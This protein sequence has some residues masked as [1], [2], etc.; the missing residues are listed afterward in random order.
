MLRRG[1]LVVLALAALAGCTRDRAPAGASD[2]FVGVRAAGKTTG[3]ASLALYAGYD[4]YAATP[5]ANFARLKAA[6][7]ELAKVGSTDRLDLFL[8]GDSG[9]A[10]D[11]FR[12]RVAR[13]QAWMGP[14][15]E[16]LGELRTND[17]PGLRDYLAWTERGGRPAAAHVAILTHGGQGGVLLDQGG[18]PT[19]PVRS[20]TLQNAARAL[21]KG[22]TGRRLDSLTLDACMMGT[23]ETGEAL[24]GVAAVLTASEDLAMMGA[25]P[26]DEVVAPL[27]E[28]KATDGAAFGAHLAEAI[29]VRGRWGDLNSRTWSALRLDAGWDRL[30]R[31]VD[32]LAGA[33]LDA[34]QA[35][36]QAVRD[37]AR[38]MPPFA[39]MKKYE[40]HYGDFHQ[41]DLVGFCRLLRAVVKAPAV[42]AAA[43]AVEADVQGVLIAFHR[44][45]S[46]TMANGLAIHLPAGMAATKIGPYLED[47]R[48]SAFARHTRWDEFLLALNGAKAEP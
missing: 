29:V 14:G 48:G 28:G 25:T 4:D 16:A 47:Y 15:F 17:T 3:R 11:S 5:E 45:P 22:H 38:A 7:A 12:A 24:K 39:L 41:R 33:L 37:V 32:R 13:G 44:R 8:A 34:L 30:V 46:E 1:L 23:I 26:W 36:P 42:H 19:A 21:A 2:A 18:K 35:E 43:R 40:P 9:V 10:N 20:M 27:A 6:H 31:D